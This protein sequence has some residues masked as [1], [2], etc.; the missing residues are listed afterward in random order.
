MTQQGTE[1]RPERSPETAGSLV[2][3]DLFVEDL[4]VPSRQALPAP[5]SREGDSRVSSVVELGLQLV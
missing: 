3:D 2:A 5:L 1:N 4:L